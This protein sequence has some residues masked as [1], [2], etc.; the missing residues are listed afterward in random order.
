MQVNNY[1]THSDTLLSPPDSASI[2]DIPLSEIEAG[3]NA[4]ST[5]SNSIH[6]PVTGDCQS[7]DECLPLRL[8]ENGL[9][10]TT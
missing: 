1:P 4:P 10:D 3:E 5:R 8:H 7:I 2:K 9:S 6:D